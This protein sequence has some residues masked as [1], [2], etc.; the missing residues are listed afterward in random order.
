MSWEEGESVNHLTYLQTKYL[1]VWK[2]QVMFQGLPSVPDYIT[3]G[4][5]KTLS[6]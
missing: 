2:N 1:T 3:E 6:F 4:G 5:T